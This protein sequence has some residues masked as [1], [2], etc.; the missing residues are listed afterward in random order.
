MEAETMGNG[1]SDLVRIPF[2][3]FLPNVML[4]L[5]FLYVLQWTGVISFWNQLFDPIYH[6]GPEWAIPS[7]LTALLILLVLFGIGEIVGLIGD[8]F[9]SIPFRLPD[10]MR[11]YHVLFFGYPNPKEY[12]TEKIE[13]KFP[14]VEKYTPFSPVSL[15]NNVFDF[16]V[17]YLIWSNEGPISE[18]SE[19]NYSIRGKIFSG[20]FALSIIYLG[21]LAYK[22]C[23]GYVLL[24]LALVGIFC[25]VF[26][27]CY[28][29]C[30]CLLQRADASADASESRIW[31]SEEIFKRVFEHFVFKPERSLLVVVFSL[32]IC[33]LPKC[34]KELSYAILAVSI[35]LFSYIEVIRAKINANALNYTHYWKIKEEETRKAKERKNQNSKSS[36]DVQR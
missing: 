30:Q 17:L 22:K 3:G 16:D 6:I 36:E 11:K 15:D 32:L 21:I 10:S 5:G 8:T 35:A 31:N 34:P 26:L 29:F 28:I 9:T 20:L 12:P 14:L 25:Y 33:K 24:A 19:T 13:C 4:G 1:W 7:W 18:I 2:F 27:S 23:P